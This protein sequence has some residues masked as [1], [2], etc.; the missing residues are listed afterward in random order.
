M[1]LL[2]L[3]A[4][5]AAAQDLIVGA[6]SVG[7]INDNGYSR[8]MHDGLMAMKAAVQGVTVL[9][10]GRTSCCGPPRQPRRSARSHPLLRLPPEVSA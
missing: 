10:A 2:P 7:S 4:A 3:V 5:W 1:A 8:A 9:E 6:I